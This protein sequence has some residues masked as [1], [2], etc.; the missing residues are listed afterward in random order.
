MKKFVKRLLLKSTVRT[1]G[2]LTRSEGGIRIL[3][4]HSIQDHE[5][6]RSH[7]APAL[8]E[9]HVRYLYENGYKSL[10]ISDIAREWPNILD[11]RPAVALTFDD[12]LENNWTNACKILKK[13]NMVGTFFI[14]TAYIGTVCQPPL[15]KEMAPYQDIPM[16]SWE[17]IEDMVR[18]GFEIGAHSHSHVM[19]AKQSPTR[20]EE[21]ILRPKKILENRLGIQITSFAYPKGHS[22]S[23]SKA[24]RKLVE[25]AGYLAACTQTGGPLRPECDLLEIPRQ[26]MSGLDSL[27]ELK[28][29][30][31]GNYD[32]LQWLRRQP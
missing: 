12:G 8:F 27:A 11:T 19:I 7:M 28:L 23:F 1:I 18:D 31:A 25:R 15:S 26:G 9:E 30:L 3:T 32:C 17:N 21:E 10:L 20:R 14:P 2:C 29:K 4:Y 24:T 22:D 6:R 16:L 13:Y 5:D